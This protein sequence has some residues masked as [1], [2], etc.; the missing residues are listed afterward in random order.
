V[1][2][3]SIDQDL[4]VRATFLRFTLGSTENPTKLQNW[5]A[6]A[7]FYCVKLSNTMNEA[8]KGPSTGFVAD[9]RRVIP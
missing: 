2:A 3:A 1:A 4:V 7:G 5:G 8:T 9:P 6:S